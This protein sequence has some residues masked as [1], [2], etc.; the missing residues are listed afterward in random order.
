MLEQCKRNTNRK[1]LKKLESVDRQDADFSEIAENSTG[2]SLRVFTVLGSHGNVCTWRTASTTIYSAG[3]SFVRFCAGILASEAL[4]QVLLTLKVC[5][6]LR[7]NR[8]K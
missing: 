5:I 8:S 1:R 7:N 6:Q 3:C 4:D 2:I